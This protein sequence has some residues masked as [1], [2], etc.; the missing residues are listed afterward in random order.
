MKFVLL[1]I[2]VMVL[3][4]SCHGS[5]SYLVV[6]R[7]Q[8]TYPDNSCCK[9]TITWHHRGIRL[10]TEG[11]A[12]WW[13]QGDKAPTMTSLPA[14]GFDSDCSDISVGEW[15][16]VERVGD[17]LFYLYYDQPNKQAKEIVVR[18][19]KEEKI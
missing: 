9:E 10:T 11:C 7:E 12:R 15:L 3:L 5:N 18:I 2:S 14:D 6:K 16:K 8:T 13:A 19:V 1:T 17:S 4:T